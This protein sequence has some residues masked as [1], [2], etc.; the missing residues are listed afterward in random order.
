MG[1]Q[2]YSQAVRDV[3]KA[4]AEHGLPEWQWLDVDALGAAMAHKL[5]SYMGE[6]VIDGIF[7]GI[8]L[9]KRTNYGLFL[10]DKG[11]ELLRE[12]QSEEKAPAAIEF[13]AI[14]YEPF[15]G[16]ERSM[17][18]G[19][20][21]MVVPRIA[22]MGVRYCVAMTPVDA[23]PEPE[24]EPEPEPLCPVC[25]K[26]TSEHRD[27]LW[28]CGHCGSEAAFGGKSANPWARHVA[29][30]TVCHLA[31]GRHRK[32]DTTRDWNRRA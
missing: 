7:P 18:P 17:S 14:A 29:E 32:C 8:C 21:V 26:T 22:K 20:L 16:V 5:V 3:V 27:G 4:I 1:K 23:A 6:Q 28:C 10:T 12:M 2:E 15:S 9:D 11:R 24:P 31:M 25:G 30:C 13:E 19:Q